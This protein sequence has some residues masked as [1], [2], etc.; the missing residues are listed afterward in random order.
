MYRRLVSLFLLPCLL[1][2]QPAAFAHS[3]GDAQPT[4]HDL[5][6]HFHS[7]TTHDRHDH[8]HSSGNHHHTHRH[9]AAGQPAE[10]VT[11]LTTQPEPLSDHDADAVYVGSVDTIAAERP[12]VEGGSKPALW[13]SV[14]S[15]VVA[16]WWR[17]N[18]DTPMVCSQPPPSRASCPLYV[19]HLA[20]HLA[21]LSR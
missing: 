4:G 12:Q 17:D 3:H 15:N 5:R 19:R 2:T 7:T 10:P 9:D 1:L 6:P 20:T 8:Y 14:P 13:W 18:P 16:A 21:A 11:C